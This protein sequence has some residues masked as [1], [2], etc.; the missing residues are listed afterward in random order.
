MVR[1]PN[2]QQGVR[3]RR[4]RPGQNPDD[5]D[6]QGRHRGDPELVNPCQFHTYNSQRIID[7]RLRAGAVKR[8]GELGV[9]MFGQMRIDD[10][11]PA[12][13]MRRTCS[14]TCI[15]RFR[16]ETSMPPRY[17]RMD[18]A[19]V[20]AIVGSPRKG[21]NTEILISRIAE[22]AA[23][24]GAAVETIHLGHVQIRECDGCHACWRGRPCSKDDDMRAIY[25]KIA[26][27][28][29]IVF[30]NARLLVRADRPDEGVHRSIRVLQ[31]RGEPAD[32]ARQAGG[33]RRRAGGNARG[34]LAARRRVLSQEPR[35]TSK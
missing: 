7:Y 27:C 1:C 16:L 11:S 6:A 3:R 35:R 4:Q 24:A 33:G 34:D 18:M 5:D 2:R 8:R 19:N 20:L 21:G 31:L 9:Q 10:C 17:R 29:T 32:G 30:G 26:A 25:A 22:G 13:T 23:S 12:F 14:H 28:E 15:A